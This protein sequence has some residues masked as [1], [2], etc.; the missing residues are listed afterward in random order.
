[1]DSL[2]AFEWLNSIL[3]VKTKSSLNECERDVFQGIWQGK[4]YQEIS[5]EP[6]RNYQYIKETGAKLFQKTELIVGVKVSKK[7]F[8]LVVEQC[9]RQS[10][11]NG[12]RHFVSKSFLLNNDHRANPFIPL[13]GVIDR[14]ELFFN[15]TQE[16]ERIFELLNNRSSVAIIGKRAIGKSS[17]LIELCRR[18]TT[19]IK[20]PRQPV[21]LNLLG[22][23]NEADFYSYFCDEIGIEDLRGYKLTRALNKRKLLLAIDEVEKMTWSGFS[24]S[25]RSYLRGLSE[26]SDAPLRLILASRTSLNDLFADGQTETMTSPLSGICIEEKL[27]VWTESTIRN[28]IAARLNN[29]PITF[30]EIEIVRLIKNTAGH[31]QKLMLQCHQLYEKKSHE[32]R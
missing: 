7:S 20:S 25:L 11:K 29:T 27:D 14:P 31:P 9:Y 3:M 30:T 12:Q 5:Q 22:V 18:A 8:R 10:Q 24:P 21:Y 4:T 23:E 28:F 19:E 6:L 32:Q 1:M 13:N 26:G 17:L 15:R 2:S 16:T